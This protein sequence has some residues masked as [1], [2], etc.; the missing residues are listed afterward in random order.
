MLSYNE[1]LKK[2][3]LKNIL[4]MKI[5]FHGGAKEVGKSCVEIV[6]NKNKRYLLDS[7]IKFIN[8]GIEYPLYLEK[9]FT[10]NGIFL[11]HAHLDHSGSLPMLEHKNLNCPIFTNKVTW[12][13]TNLLLE[14]SYH[15]AQLK[16]LHPAYI[17]RDIY[18][19]SKDIKFVSYEKQYVT[20]DND[21][22]FTFINSGHIPG[23]CSILLDLEDKK[24]LYTGDINTNNTN[25]MIGSEIG[26]IQDIDILITETTYGDR[27]HPDFE[28]TETDFLLMIEKAIKRGGSA[29]IPVFGVGRAQEILILL[30]RLNVSA[31][32]YIDGMAKK[33]TEF[34][35]DT[36]NKYV[37]NI[38]VLKEMYDKAI[39]VR[40]PV[41]RKEIAKKSGVIVLTTSGM[42][43]GGPVVTYAKS[44]LLEQKN[45]L[46][47]TGYQVKGTRGRSV[48]E[49]RLYYCDHQRI[50]V[51]ATV[52][53]FDFSAHL[54]KEDIQNL[55]QKIKPKTVILNHGD[56]EALESVALWIKQELPQIKVIVPNIGEVLEF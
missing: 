49:D 29:L 25:L 26:K 13:I 55:I 43:Q 39:K 38:E 53:K 45:Y 44:M 31:P 3:L 54:G 14:D 40:N 12:K 15:L 4:K 22:K 34:V 32:I 10:L 33:V 18:K 47:L 11:S 41:H 21:M 19:V 16:H 6:S 17:E 1:Y 36:N 9:V 20:K 46:L 56:L 35:I 48:F 37:N 7:G 23:S 24:V 8:G 2:I 27:K 52:K 51:L 42:M 50:N 5:I 30:K 28:Q